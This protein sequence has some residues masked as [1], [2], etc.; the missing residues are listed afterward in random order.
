MC[1]DLV[2]EDPSGDTQDADNGPKVFIE[3]FEESSRLQMQKQ[4][5]ASTKGRATRN[6]SLYC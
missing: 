1:S 5:E 4:Q 3:I 2:A 6:I